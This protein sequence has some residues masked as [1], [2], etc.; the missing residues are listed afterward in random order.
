MIMFDDDPIGL[1]LTNNLVVFVAH[2]SGA[3]LSEVSNIDLIPQDTL[4]SDHTPQVVGVA[5]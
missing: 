2:R 4:D 3:H 5:R 1:V